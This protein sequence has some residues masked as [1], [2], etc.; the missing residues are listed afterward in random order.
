MEGTHRKD[1][2]WDQ[3]V[4]TGEVEGPM[5]KVTRELDV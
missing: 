4:E 3:I 2:E 1:H 5:E